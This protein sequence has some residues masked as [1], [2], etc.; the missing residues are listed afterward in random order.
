MRCDRRPSADVV[1]L[2]L[3]EQRAVAQIEQL[4]RVGAVA[5]GLLERAQDQLAL[6]ASRR[7]LDRQI[8]VGKLQRPADLAVHG[9]PRADAGARADCRGRSARP[10]T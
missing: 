2:D 4:G 3:V 7:A 9:G 8:V 5:A 1:V 10:H 6:E